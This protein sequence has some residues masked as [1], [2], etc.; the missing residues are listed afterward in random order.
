MQHESHISDEPNIGVGVRI[1]AILLVLI[2]IGAI[3]AYVVFGSGMWNP[4]PVQHS[5]Y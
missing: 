2:V 5:A 4:P 1:V 3:V